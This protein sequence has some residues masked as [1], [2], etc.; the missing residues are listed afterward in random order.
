MLITL[1]KIARTYLMGPSLSCYVTKI[2]M[3]IGC[4][5]RYL[6]S[7]GLFSRAGLLQVYFG[8]VF[9]V[10]FNVIFSSIS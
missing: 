6:N 10:A 2:L 3:E 5:P 4:L 9:K 1:R 8:L 7:G